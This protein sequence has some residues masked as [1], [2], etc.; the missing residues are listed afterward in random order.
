LNIESLILCLAIKRQTFDI[1]RQNSQTSTAEITK[2]QQTTRLAL[3]HFEFISLKLLFYLP[4]KKSAESS[5]QLSSSTSIHEN[6]PHFVFAIKLCSASPIH[7]HLTSK[8]EKKGNKNVRNSKRNCQQRATV[9]DDSQSALPH[10]AK[11]RTTTG[12]S[13]EKK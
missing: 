3:S 11:Q 5:H 13:G 8:R 9:S 2:Q 4:E 7:F 10:S 6:S 1:S 12:G